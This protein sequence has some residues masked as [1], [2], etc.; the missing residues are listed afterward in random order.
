MYL[1]VEMWKPRSSW[2][3]VPTEQR[4]EFLSQLVHGVERMQKLEVELVGFTLGEEA[5]HNPLDYQYMVVWKMPNKGHIHMLEKAVRAEGWD[6]FFTISHA[7]GKIT[8]VKEL[9]T[10]MVKA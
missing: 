6:N 4:K 2:S 9:I 7:C 5:Q 8:P 3:T 1:Y 10:D